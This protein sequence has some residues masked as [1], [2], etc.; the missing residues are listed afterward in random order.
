MPRIRTVKPSYFSDAKVCKLS[1]EAELLF[2]GMWCFADCDGYL[3]DDEDQIRMD[4]FPSRPH[5]RIP[6][7]LD[8]LLLSGMLVACQPTTGRDALWIRNFTRHQRKKKE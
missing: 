8:E 5:I 7:L 2:L 1:V 6:P 4:V 3:W